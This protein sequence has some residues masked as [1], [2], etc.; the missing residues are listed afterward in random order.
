MEKLFLA[1]L[2]AKLLI[3]QSIL[4]IKLKFLVKILDGSYS[5]PLALHV[6]NS[7]KAENKAKEASRW[8]QSIIQ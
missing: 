6:H 7:L 3:L 2:W 1:T 8:P 5:E 4:E